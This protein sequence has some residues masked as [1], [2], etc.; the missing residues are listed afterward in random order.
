[1]R[2]LESKPGWGMGVHEQKKKLVHDDWVDEVTNSKHAS[3][4]ARCRDKHPQSLRRGQLF[5][6]RLSIWP[7]PRWVIA[8]PNDFKN[9]TSSVNPVLHGTPYSAGYPGASPK[10]CLYIELHARERSPA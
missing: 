5:L 2:Q 1:M 3:A 4:S 7:V 6:G 9:R 8:C 10:I